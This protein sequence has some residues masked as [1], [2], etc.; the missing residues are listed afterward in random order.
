MQVATCS[1]GSGIP[2][3]KIHIKGQAVTVVGLPLIFQQFQQEGKESSDVIARQ[4]LE[5]VKIY[6]AVPEEAEEAYATALLR[7]YSA[8]CGKKEPD[9]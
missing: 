2:I 7:E 9:R 6:N 4:L 3:Q 1:C 8:F 5:V